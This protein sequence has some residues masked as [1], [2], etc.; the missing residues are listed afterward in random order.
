MLVL[1]L[2]VVVEVGVGVGCGNGASAAGA[3][4]RVGGGWRGGGDDEKMLKMAIMT[5]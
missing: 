3:A 4:G 5:T 1:A 2:V